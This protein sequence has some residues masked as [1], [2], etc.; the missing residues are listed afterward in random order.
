MDEIEGGQ[1]IE[2]VILDHFFFFFFF[3]FDPMR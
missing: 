3:F 2:R 1:K